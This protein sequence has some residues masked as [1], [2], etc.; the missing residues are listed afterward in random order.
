MTGGSSSTGGGG[1]SSPADKFLSAFKESLKKSSFDPVCG[2]AQPK[3]S[4]ISIMSSSAPFVGSASGEGSSSGGSATDAG[5]AASGF[6][7]GGGSGGRVLDRLLPSSSPLSTVQSKATPADDA[8]ISQMASMQWPT[9]SSFT[10]QLEAAAGEYLTAISVGAALGAAV[11]AGIGMGCVAASGLTSGVRYVV[12]TFWYGV[13]RTRIWIFEY[14]L[15]RQIQ[16]TIDYG[17]RTEYTSAT[18][19]SSALDDADVTPRNS[20]QPRSGQSAGEEMSRRDA[21]T[22]AKTSCLG[23]GKNKIYVIQGDVTSSPTATAATSAEDQC[24][25]CLDALVCE[26]GKKLMGLQHVRR[27]TAY[28]VTGSCDASIFR[29]ILTKEYPISLGDLVL[30]VMFVQRLEDDIAFVQVEALASL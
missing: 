16:K 7:A 20:N 14:L 9:F 1:S 21:S 26:L 10:D 15:G 25:Q 19:D 12:P 22:G 11:A 28:L 18:N 30:S 17:E 6:A 8:I 27:L 13:L 2:P 29:S 5:S 24:R 3:S 4:L 23:S